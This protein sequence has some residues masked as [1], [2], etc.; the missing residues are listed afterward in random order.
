MNKPNHAPFFHKVM[1]VDDN[2]TDRY[3]ATRIIK[4]YAFAEEIILKESAYSALYHLKSLENTP[5]ELPNLIFLDIRM[6]ERDGFDFLEDYQNLPETIKKHCVI[7][8]LSTS[9]NPSDHERAKDS[10]YVTQ[11]LN[12]PLS[13][14]ALDKILLI[15]NSIS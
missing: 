11:F 3:I 13:K 6:P 8:M 9:L 2:E 12:K 15:A 1:V 5:E 10:G 7:V 14:N 4:K